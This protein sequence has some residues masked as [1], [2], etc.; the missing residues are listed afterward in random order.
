MPKLTCPYCHILS[1]SKYDHVTH[2]RNRHSDLHSR[3]IQRGIDGAVSQKVIQ[4]RLAAPIVQNIDSVS[5]CV[6]GD[7]AITIELAREVPTI[8]VGFEGRKRAWILSFKLPSGESVKIGLSDD[9][10][11]VLSNRIS[12][13]LILPVGEPF[14]VE[15]RE[16]SKGD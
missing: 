15:V 4:T 8:D 16:K 13:S 11:R 3:C 1:Q 10:L 12:N 2:L 14:E 7:E 6:E 5:V 9:N